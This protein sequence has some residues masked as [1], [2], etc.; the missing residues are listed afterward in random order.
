M[1]NIELLDD[2]LATIDEHPENWNQ[3]LYA[4]A[5]PSGSFAER[6]RSGDPHPTLELN[7][8][9]GT[10]FCVAGWAAVKTG[11]E[12]DWYVGFWHDPNVYATRLKNGEEIHM[13]ARRV[14]DL[15]RDDA[16]ILFDP[17]NTREDLQEMRDI[18]ASGESL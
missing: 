13:Y 2:I 10:A 6:L 3:G 17:L 5:D 12:I 7:A 1:A 18:L 8:T 9:C 11:A 4:V 14:L 16:I 15:S